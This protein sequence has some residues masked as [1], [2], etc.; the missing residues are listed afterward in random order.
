LEIVLGRCKIGAHFATNVPSAQ[1][2]V[3][4]APNGTPR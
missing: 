3:L 1:K 4:D 2:I